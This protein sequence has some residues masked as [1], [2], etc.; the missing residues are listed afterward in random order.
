HIK[1]IIN[2]KNNIEI[3]SQKCINYS[4][5]DLPNK[6][7]SFCNYLNYLNNYSK[8]FSSLLDPNKD[9]SIFNLLNS[10]SENIQIIKELI[11]NKTNNTNESIINKLKPYNLE[12][13][14]DNLVL[15]DI[16]NINKFIFEKSYDNSI[17]NIYEDTI[18]G[19]IEILKNANQNITLNIYLDSFD[20]N[21]STPLF[22]EKVN[23]LCNN[24]IINNIYSEDIINQVRENILLRFS[25]EKDNI[26]SLSQLDSNS[27]NNIKK[28]LMTTLINE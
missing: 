6:N 22:K 1:S 10:L 28:D 17:N 3:K 8:Y 26:L 4:I 13:I 19:Q 25:S 18:K 27:T 11:I 7:N 24:Y 21:I 5:Y 12:N 15:K 16:S 9:S 2:E 20:Y 23:S 14:K